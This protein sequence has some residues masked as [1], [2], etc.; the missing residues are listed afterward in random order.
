[1]VKL[2]RIFKKFISNPLFVSLIFFVFSA[3]TMIVLFIPAM[4]IRKEAQKHSVYKA[5]SQKAAKISYELHTRINI[6]QSIASYIELNPNITQQDFSAFVRTILENDDNGVISSMSYEKDLVITFIA[7]LDLNKKAKGLD[8]TLRSGRRENL[9][10]AIENKKSYVEG[11]F[12]VEQNYIG[13]VSYIPV[14]LFDSLTS[15]RKAVGVTD[16][17][18]FWERFLKVTGL[19]EEDNFIEIAIRGENGA[20]E[21]GAVFYGDPN[22]FKKEDIVKVPIILP[23]GEWILAAYP[24]NGWDS[25]M[26]S[27]TIEF[28]FGAAFVFSL[29]IY[30]TLRFS[31]E[32]LQHV[33]LKY[34]KITETSR[35]I[36]WVIDAATLSYTYIN[37]ACRKYTGYTPEEY[38]KMSV[39]DT[40]TPVSYEKAIAIINDAFASL[41]S[42]EERTVEATFEAQQYTKW[43]TINWIEIS[44]TSAKDKNGRFSEIIGT[45]RIINN[46]KELEAKLKENEKKLL[47]INENSTDLI[48]ILDALSMELIYESAS[49]VHMHGYTPEELKHRRPLDT[50]PQET[51]D[52]IMRLIQQKT[53]QF[54]NGE[55]SRIHATFETPLIRKDSSSVW[56]EFSVTAITDTLGNPI[57]YLGITKNIE[58]RKS[59]EHQISKQA[60]ELQKL[61]ATKNRFFSIMAHD[62]KNPISSLLKVC[63]Y[64]IENYQ[65]KRENAVKEDIAMLHD[66]TKHTYKLLDNLLEWSRSQ[67]GS[68][69]YTPTEASLLKIIN[70]CINYS[71]VQAEAK[72]ITITFDDSL[73]SE[74]LV[75]CDVNMIH[76][77]LRNLV[78]NALKFSFNNSTIEIKITN[79]KQ[80]DS[81]YQVSVKDWGVGI[82][83]VDINKLFKIDEKMISSRGTNDEIGTGLGL[84]LCKD[85]IDKHNCKIWVESKK[86][87]ETT[88][89]FILPKHHP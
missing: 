40:L 62:L 59:L 56:T 52:Y 53:T 39:R 81:Y 26:L 36:V 82:D 86:G 84:I 49:A 15:E 14:Y 37:D 88:F 23:L 22:I 47:A 48:W 54:K 70:D 24:K 30:F 32:Q 71:K 45:T 80:N 87:K 50:L 33:E 68:I 64:L 63:E 34:R 77:V 20:G 69:V 1:M 19:N 57:E 28:S 29:L 18:I 21:D 66:A 78:S 12:E 41:K 2:S 79:Y 44:A 42:E 13:L 75:N 74:G 73:D 3:A 83:A 35:D 16:V 25:G 72:N 55:I 8:L 76:T 6:N 17:V 51:K 4:E 27:F 85:F 60:E 46:K 89:F 11:P 31:Q 65:A 5:A 9:I 67:M 10:K 61:H 7:P 58:S 38:L 43:G